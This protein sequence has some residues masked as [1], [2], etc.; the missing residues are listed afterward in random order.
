MEKPSPG[1]I[2]RR[3][4]EWYG[5]HR[6]DLPWR[7]TTDPYAIWVSEIMLQQTGVETVVPFY[8]RFMARF[9]TVEALAAAPLD[10]V[11]KA[12]ENLGYYGRARNLHRAARIVV[13]EMGGRLPSDLSAL[14]SLP[15]IGKYTAGAILSMAFGK[16]VPALDGNVRRVLSR[17][18][19][20]PEAVDR[21]AGAKILEARA[22]DLV[23]EETPGTF[24]QSLMELGAL[25]CL[26]R[27]PRCPS[28][29]IA[30]SCEGRRRGIEESL[31]VTSPK[32][33]LPTR[34]F[35][36]ALLR[37]ADGRCLLVRRPEKGLLSGLWAFPTTAWNGADPVAWLEEQ[38][39]AAVREIEALPAVRHTYTHFR[40]VVH[41]FL[42]RLGEAAPKMEARQ[43]RAWVGFREFDR[44]ALSALD[45]KLLKNLLPRENGT[46]RPSERSGG[47]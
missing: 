17:L 20:L 21:P 7:R 28:C 36:T 1:D 25:V 9:P 12:W 2:P 31:P 13:N 24:N 27:T 19:A 22:A 33:P 32:G 29:P 45:R 40:A 10:D 46:E 34:T 38:A 14:L 47:P 37:S 18:F 41:P 26:P 4:T 35:V 3:L 42:C 23:P 15:G 44:Y 8:V 11:L 43:G 16:P 6:R 39:G 5:R 30:S